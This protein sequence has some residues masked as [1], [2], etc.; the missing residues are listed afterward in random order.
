MGKTVEPKQVDVARLHENHAEIRAADWRSPLI[1]RLLRSKR[2]RDG[3]QVFSDS[4]RPQGGNDIERQLDLAWE[5]LEKDFNQTVKTY[6]E[7]DL[8][9]YAS[10]GLA[11]V[12]L[13]ERAGLQI[14]E[15]TR[16]GDRA[17]YWI[18]EVRMLEVS[19]QQ[20]G[21]LETL[22]DE[23]ARQLLEN[24]YKNSGFVCVAN[25]EDRKSYLWFFEQEG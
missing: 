4:F 15:V 18:G 20:A 8:T 13:H 14:T 23:K 3:N 10:L 12:L 11:C 9:E 6:Q 5:G 24:P 21:N 7:P 17:D 1:R 2:Y 25:Y 19:G 22:R 16:R